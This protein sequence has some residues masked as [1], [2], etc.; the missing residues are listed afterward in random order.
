MLITAVQ[1]DHAGESAT[2]NKQRSWISQRRHSIATPQPSIIRVEGEDEMGDVVSQKPMRRWESK[3]TR[4]R[5]SGISSPYTPRFQA[6]DEV[7]DP[8]SHLAKSWPHAP[9]SV[10]KSRIVICLYLWSIRQRRSVYGILLPKHSMLSMQQQRIP[11][12][13]EFCHMSRSDSCW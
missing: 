6:F 13:A 11:S 7:F 5:L 2:H 10:R 12:N 8:S 3:S 4:F 1:D 9:P